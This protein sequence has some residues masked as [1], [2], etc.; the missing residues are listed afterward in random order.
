M[1]TMSIQAG[2]PVI[3]TNHSLRSYGATKSSRAHSGA[4]RASLYR[5]IAKVRAHLR[6]AEDDH[7][8]ST[9]W[10]QW[11]RE[12]ICI[13]STIIIWCPVWASS[14]SA[15]SS[16][17]ASTACM[18]ATSATAKTLLPSAT[19]T[20]LHWMHLNGCTF[21]INVI[22]KTDSYLQGVDVREL[23]SDF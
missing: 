18:V 12:T 13:C 11:A 2:L 16:Y 8:K 6:K 4:N 14:P 10:H 20:M 19:D 3:H 7:F 15:S 1:K 17:S 5:G 22:Q 23:F 9:K 21:I